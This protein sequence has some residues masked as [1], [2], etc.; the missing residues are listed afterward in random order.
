MQMRRLA[1]I[2]NSAVRT[3]EIE[4]QRRP[5]SG[6]L[7]ERVDHQIAALVKIEAAGKENSIRIGLVQIPQMIIGPRLDGAG[8]DFRVFQGDPIKVRAC[9]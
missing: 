5:R 4:D 1:R 2:G 8:N 7:H 3:D 9:G 6:Q